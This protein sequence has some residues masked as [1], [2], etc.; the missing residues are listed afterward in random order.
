MPRVPTQLLADLYERGWSLQAVAAHVGLDRSTV[1]AA[2][3]RHG[4]QRRPAGRPVTHPEA[5]RTR[6]RQLRD[7]GASYELIAARLGV[8]SSTVWRWLRA[9]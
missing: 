1:H 8:G 9:A 4:V 2:L 5:L 7:E 6:A 3:T